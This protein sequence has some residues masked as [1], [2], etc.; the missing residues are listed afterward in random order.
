MII[1]SA[2]FAHA[3]ATH[4]AVGSA[5]TELKF[6]PVCPITFFCQ[7]NLATIKISAKNI[8]IKWIT[9]IIPEIGDNSVFISVKN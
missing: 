4:V 2:R 1:E 7:K 3:E 6:A 5:V 9:V 8:I